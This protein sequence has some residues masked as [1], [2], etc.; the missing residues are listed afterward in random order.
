MIH[1]D[2]NGM[3]AESNI[4]GFPIGMKVSETFRGSP[5]G[6][7]VT[8][9]LTVEDNSNKSVEDMFIG[10]PLTEENIKRYKELKSKSQK[11]EMLDK[12]F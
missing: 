2:E 5:V 12:I 8:H 9:I 7:Y 1:C 3:I 11:K 10:L 6:G 4:Y